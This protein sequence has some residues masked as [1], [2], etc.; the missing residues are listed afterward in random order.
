MRTLAIAMCLSLLLTGCVRQSA[1]PTP[2]SEAMALCA[3]LP[4]PLTDSQDDWMAWAADVIDL[5]SACRQRHG[6]LVDWENR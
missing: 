3:A 1:R 2:P 5:Y 6:A 4:E